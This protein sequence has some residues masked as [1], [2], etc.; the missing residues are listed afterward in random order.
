MSG[1]FPRKKLSVAILSRSTTDWLHGL[2]F[3]R[4]SFIR[5]STHHLLFCSSSHSFNIWSIRVSTHPFALWFIRSSTHSFA[6]SFVH[7]P[8]PVLIGSSIR[9]PF[10]Y[11]LLRAYFT[12]TVCMMFLQ[13]RLLLIYRL[14]VTQHGHPGPLTSRCQPRPRV[15]TSN[16]AGSS[17]HCHSV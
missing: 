15:D 17:N 2:S 11:A 9:L 5:S 8:I 4:S 3:F 13:L 6:R 12:L 1:Q 7:S 10:R 16:K 14:T